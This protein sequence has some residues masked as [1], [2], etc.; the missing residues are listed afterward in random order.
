MSKAKPTKTVSVEIVKPDESPSREGKLCATT[1]SNPL[2]PEFGDINQIGLWLKNEVCNFER[3][4]RSL[5]LRMV[6]IGMVLVWVEKTQ[7]RGT[8]A[9]LLMLHF[10]QRSAKQLEKYIAAA[11][12]VMRHLDLLKGNTLTNASELSQVVCFQPDLFDDA[13][14]LKHNA[15]LQKVSD[16][17]GGRSLSK[18]LNEDSPLALGEA[19][20]LPNTPNGHQKDAANKRQVKPLEMVK[21]E[22]F[23][24][25]FNE[26]L[27]SFKAKEWQHCY[28]HA[29]PDPGSVGLLTLEAELKKAHEAVA[30]HNREQALK[31]RTNTRKR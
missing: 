17:I 24:K 18:L 10:G 7:P 25:A 6:R 15:I 9:N 12:K 2:I 30:Q 13:E 29:L 21:R 20:E 16:F 22:A 8:Q 14:T 3:D 11:K 26:F 19:P 5:T 27:A 4:E 28:L 31:D 23:E 1:L